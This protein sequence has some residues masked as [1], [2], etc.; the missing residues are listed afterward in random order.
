MHSL[1]GGTSKEKKSWGGVLP[2]QGD[3][4][5]EK[6]G[7]RAIAARKSFQSRNVSRAGLERGGN[8]NTGG[9]GE[10][11]EGVALQVL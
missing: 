8:P 1:G 7:M 2:M 6:G 4:V 11:A 10:W 5:L 9:L 3:T